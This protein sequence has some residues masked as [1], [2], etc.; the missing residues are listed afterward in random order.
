MHWAVEKNIKQAIC[1]EFR[2]QLFGVRYTAMTNVELI[3]VR[4]A[5]GELDGIDNLHTGLKY[6][7]DCMTLPKANK[8]YGV[9]LIVDDN[10]RILV[11]H[12]VLQE[13]LKRADK[14]QGRSEFVIIGDM[15]DGP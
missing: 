11:K 3:A 6:L 12:T 8:T 15:A 14:A 1:A 10:S 5:T 9:G 13:K 4:Y 2:S 7:V